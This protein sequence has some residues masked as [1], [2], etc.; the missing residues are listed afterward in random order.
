[1]NAAAGVPEALTR[2]QD[3]LATRIA[4]KSEQTGPAARPAETKPAGD[5]VSISRE[6]RDKAAAMQNSQAAD[7]AEGREGEKTTF[8]MRQGK[9]D[10]AG[11]ADKEEAVDE[12][13]DTNSDIKK[14]KDELQEAKTAFFG[15][16]EEQARKIKD[17]KQDIDDLEDTKKQLESELSQ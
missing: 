10:E 11:D 8:T 14:K 12:L 2:A 6:G 1:M 13:K 4:Q 9:G 16:E 5:S 15:S 3:V 7:S 17:L